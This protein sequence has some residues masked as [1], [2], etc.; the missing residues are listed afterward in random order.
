[1][2][3]L[4]L[5]KSERHLAVRFLDGVV[6]GNADASFELADVLDVGVDPRAIGSTQP[7]LERA[8]LPHNRIKDAGVAL[9]I[10]QP[11]LRAGTV[12]EQA[13]EHDPGVDLRRQRRR[14]RRPRNGVGVGAAVTPVAVPEVAG[15]FD[16]QLQR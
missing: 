7:G 15:V 14:W 3:V 12:S 13:L 9:P 8:E 2:F 1:M 4:A 5:W 11:L 10:P 6:H 16:T